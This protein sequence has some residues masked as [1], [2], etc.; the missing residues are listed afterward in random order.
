LSLFFVYRSPYAGPTG[1]LVR[2]LDADTILEWFRRS[3]D[4]AARGQDEDEWATSAMKWVEAELGFDVY[5]LW[6]IFAAVPELA[7]SPPE[8]D[9]QLADYLSKYLGVEGSVFV[10]PRAIQAHTNDDELELVYYLFD[11]PFAREH[12]ERTAYLLHEGWRLPAATGD[13]PFSPDI[14]VPELS[15]GGSG[16]GTTYL[17][18]L[19]PHPRLYFED[20]SRDQ[21]RRIEGVRL[22]DLGDS[23]RGA[24]P[25]PDWPLELRLLRLAACR[26]GGDWPRAAFDR[27]VGLPLDQ[28]KAFDRNR[29][30]WPSARKMGLAGD[31]LIGSPERAE[32]ELEAFLR[33]V[34]PFVLERGH[35]ERD[36]WPS[37][38][39]LD[40]HLVQFSIRPFGS[41]FEGLYH[42]W[43]LF[44]DRWAGKNEHLAQSLR[45]SSRWDVL[46]D[47][48]PPEVS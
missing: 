41:Y 24:G 42:Q 6:S 34:P 16:E 40:R 30:D 35:R 4:V 17:V 13:R 27:A 28:L 37:S 48:K 2:R 14:D 38:I 18:F 33:L 22:P 43:I 26:A 11:E 9:D 1:K 32:A 5:D 46:S 19:A 21:P 3:W 29:T 12:P 39:A 15:W 45:Y 20:I 8:S 36:Q 7:L 47:P 25:A 23:L 31:I 44:D 10:S